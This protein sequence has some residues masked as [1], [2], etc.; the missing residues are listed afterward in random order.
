MSAWR[1]GALAS[2]AKKASGRRA[3]RHMVQGM[4]ARAFNSWRCNAQICTAERYAL[5]TW[6]VPVPGADWE[7]LDLHLRLMRNGFTLI[8]TGA[9]WRDACTA[10]LP[11]Q[12]QT[13]V[14]TSKFQNQRKVPCVL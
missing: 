6:L 5:T 12:Q 3:V 13:Q 2:L 9:D 11:L 14:P 8:D 1:R 4:A 10:D 7:L